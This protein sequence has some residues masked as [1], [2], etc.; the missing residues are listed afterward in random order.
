MAL[1]IQERLAQLRISNN[2]TDNV[3]TTLPKKEAPVSAANIVVKGS[4]NSNVGNINNNKD[5]TEGDIIAPRMVEL[6]VVA[7]LD[8][9]PPKPGLTLV[10]RLA[11]VAQKGKSV[12]ATKLNVETP[13]ERSIR[14]A[15]QTK[16]EQ[17]VDYK[18]KCVELRGRIT[19]MDALLTESHKE[20]NKAEYRI[21]ELDSQIT[22]LNNTIK[23]YQ[24]IE[25]KMNALAIRLNDVGA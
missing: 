20:T 2:P 1:T 16:E 6:P 3:S 10:E 17:T 9:V 25:A 23:D 12:E 14:I 5:N 18:A 19:H 22:A 7:I 4:N 15:Q 11:R 21:E 24:D 13:G 8:N